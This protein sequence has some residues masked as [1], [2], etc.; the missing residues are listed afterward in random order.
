M[1]ELKF[2]RGDCDIKLEVYK[3][4]NIGGLEIRLPITK[5]SK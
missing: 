2:E 1:S 4:A 3:A 5:D